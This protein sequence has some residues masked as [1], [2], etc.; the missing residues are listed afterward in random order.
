M[1][2]VNRNKG[3]EQFQER[4]YERAAFWVARL[5]ADDCSDEDLQ[6]FALWLSANPAHSQAMDTLLT[7]WEDLAVLEHMPLPQPVPIAARARQRTG[8][9]LAAAACALFAV[10]LL[11]VQQQANKGLYYQTAVG[12]QQLITLSD[13]SSVTLNT[14]TRISVSFEEN[15]RQVELNRGE[16]YFEVEK[17]AQRPFV[18]D[19]G[20]AEV[21][22]IGTAF[23]I[24][25]QDNRS[26]I[27]VTE[28]VVRVT[29]KGNP[30]TRA[31]NTE[32]LYANQRLSTNASGLARGV[33]VEIAAAETAWRDGKLVAQ[34][35]PLA[36]LI[37]ELSRYHERTIMIAEP[38][39]AQT[40]VSGVFNLNQPDTILAAL[41][42]SIGVHAMELEDHS[43]LLI[44]TSL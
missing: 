35:M 39:L 8:L 16:A 12:E 38:E 31:A 33:S 5:R 27:M 4:M 14:N 10:L 18:V 6:D 17:D 1:S 43:V 40:K 13:G 11:P 36:E 28:G 3:L 19:L 2:L 23:N 9:A 21:R 7:L 32:V 15:L 37:K 29:E 20:N 24:H 41:E 44:K 26:D 42:H 25:M 34:A 30:G 22:V